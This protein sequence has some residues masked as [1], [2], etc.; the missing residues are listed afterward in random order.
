MELHHLHVAQ[1]QPRAQR[2]REAVAGLVA[3]GRVVPVHRR[4]AAGREQRP[5]CACTNTNSPVR[6]STSSTP[7]SASPR[8]VRTNSTARCSSSRWMPR[9]HTCSARRLMI[10]MPVRSPLCT[11]RSKV[12][13]A[14]AFW[15]IVPSG[16]RSK[17]QPSSFSSSWMRSTAPVTSVQASS[18]SRQ[19]LAALDRVHEVA[20]DRVAGGERDVVAALDHARAAALAEQ[21]LHRDRDVE[22]RIRGVA[23]AARRRGRRRRSR[24]S[25]VGR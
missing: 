20:L 12:W 11:V 1:R 25:G 15:W 6:M 16:L 4:A 21:A 2:H 19:P 17:K 10:S 23:R 3:G 24:G 14:N 5:R 13:P 8:R 18:W 22:L 7:A 9:A